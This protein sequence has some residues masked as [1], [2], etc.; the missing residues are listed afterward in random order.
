MSDISVF[1]MDWLEEEAV[2]ARVSV[3]TGPITVNVLTSLV[4]KT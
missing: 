3:N 4:I 1:D 2:H